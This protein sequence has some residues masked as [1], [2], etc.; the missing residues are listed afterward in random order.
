MGRFSWAAAC[1]VLLLLLVVLVLVLLL[2]AVRREE[3]CLRRVERM[4][5]L[6][7]FRSRGGHFVSSACTRACLRLLRRAPFVAV[8]VLLAERQLGRSHCRRMLDCS[9]SS[10]ESTGC[11]PCSS[12]AI[13]SQRFMAAVD[14]VPVKFLSRA[15]ASHRLSCIKSRQI[16]CERASGSAGVV[17]ARRRVV[18]ER[19][20]PGMNRACFG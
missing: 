2:L 3:C 10:S 12:R 18:R 8:C 9:S 20:R 6:I 11:I 7:A 14:R 15:R 16:A 1:R 19:D 4:K 17:A 13:D 5:A